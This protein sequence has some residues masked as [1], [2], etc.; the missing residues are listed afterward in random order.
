MAKYRI[1]TDDGQMVILDSDRA[2]ESWP[3]ETR[4]DGNNHVSLVTGS[5]WVHET[6]HLSAKGR[7][8]V[9]TTSQWQGSTDTARIVTPHE[10]AAWMVLCGHD[11]PEELEQA[12]AEVCE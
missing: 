4:W 5:Q 6:L 8:W 7:W 3:E 2:R 10:A 1:E 12:E 11:L 9:E